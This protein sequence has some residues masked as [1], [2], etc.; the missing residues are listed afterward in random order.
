MEKHHF[1]EARQQHEALKAF[2][3]LQVMKEWIDLG[4]LYA[5]P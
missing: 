5:H 3:N 2:N 4:P 1:F